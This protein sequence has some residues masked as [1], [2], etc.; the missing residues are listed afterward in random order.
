MTTQ[1]QSGGLLE[2]TVTQNNPSGRIYGCKVDIDIN[3][4]RAASISGLA[5]TSKVATTSIASF[6]RRGR[7]SPSIPITRSSIDSSM[8]VLAAV[9]A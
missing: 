2:V 5:P 6:G 4:K 7:R 3:G 9:E 1:E 8:R